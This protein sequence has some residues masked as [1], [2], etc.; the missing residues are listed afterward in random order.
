M[1]DL[2]CVPVVILRTGAAVSIFKFGLSWCWYPKEPG[3]QHSNGRDEGRLGRRR[4]VVN[5]DP[6]IVPDLKAHV[7]FRSNMARNKGMDK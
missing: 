3:G 7:S 6:K 4:L 1:T 5:T 2:K